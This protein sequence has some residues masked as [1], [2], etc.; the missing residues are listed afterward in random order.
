MTY[1]PNKTSKSDGGV[2]P[3]IPSGRKRTVGTTDDT[4]VLGR[5]SFLVVSRQLR[6]SDNKVEVH[7]TFFKHYR[8]SI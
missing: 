8:K 4:G 2:N 5:S 3:W 1:P 6:K 7:D